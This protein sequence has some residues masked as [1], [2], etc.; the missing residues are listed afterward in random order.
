MTRQPT[1]QERIAEQLTGRLDDMREWL[2]DYA[3][4]DYEEPPDSDALSPYTGPL[5]IDLKT[6]YTILLSTGGPGD[7]LDVT[8]SD[9][10]IVRIEY[11]FKDWYDGARID[12]TGADFDAMAEWLQFLY[13][14]RFLNKIH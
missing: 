12:V 2:D 1:C 6:V 8:I 5:S 13:L 4:H 7:E 3:A 14:E 11:V 9:G 10:E